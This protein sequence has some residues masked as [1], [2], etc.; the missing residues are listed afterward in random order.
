VLLS[1]GNRQ[2]EV[3]RVLGVCERTVARW[4][5]EPLFRSQ[6]EAAHEDAM[7]SATRRLSEAANDAAAKLAS[8]TTDAI[9]ERVQLAA[10]QAT[11][12]LG[13][14]LRAEQGLEDRLAALEAR[15]AA[16]ELEGPRGVS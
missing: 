12:T 1:A 14:R 2:K 3:S 13:L 5:T 7:Q 8:L 16:T 15:L 10:A 6:L 9:D 4:C 11:L